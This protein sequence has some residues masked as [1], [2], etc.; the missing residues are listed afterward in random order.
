VPRNDKEKRKRGEGVRSRRRADTDISNV[1]L[2]GAFGNIGRHTLRELLRQG[3]RVRCFDVPSNANRR[4][5]AEFHGRVEVVWGDICSSDNVRAALDG[6]HAVIHNAAIIPSASEKRPE[7]AKAVN[8][9]GTRHVVDA[10]KAA[11]RNGRVPYLVFPSSISVFGPSQHKKPPRR[12]SEPVRASDHYTTHKIACERMIRAARIPHVV[13]RVGAALDPAGVG[14]DADIDSM[15]MMFEMS[16]DNRVEY[17]HPADV[18]RAQVNALRCPAASGKVL[19]I[20][21]GPQCQIR[22]RDMFDA[23]FSALGLQGIPPEAF[24]DRNYYTDWMDTE[25]SQRLLD[26]QRV[27]WTD[28]RRDLERNLGLYRWLLYPLRPLAKHYL[29]RYS[30]P[31]QRRTVTGDG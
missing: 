1:L 9:D 22:Q 19:L 27:T 11:R 29:L 6:Q 3:Y 23:I 18:A 15:I 31:W 16:P 28:F 20:G 14:M 21:G 25:E 8:I 4:A 30:A 24:G 5:A 2:T 12:A 26:F 7:I 17:V 10:I 13:L